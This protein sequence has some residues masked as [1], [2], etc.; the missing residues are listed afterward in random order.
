MRK[1]VILLI[2]ILVLISIFSIAYNLV[3]KYYVRFP[4]WSMDPRYEI[5]TIDE[6]FIT[7]LKPMQ[8][9]NT[10]FFPVKLHMAAIQVSDYEGKLVALINM[11]EQ[12]ILEPKSVND[13]KL[14]VALPLNLLNYPHLTERNKVD[15][16]FDGTVQGSVYSFPFTKKISG[17]FSLSP[18]AEWAEKIFKPLL[19]K[20]MSQNQLI[21]FKGARVIS[22]RVVRLEFIASTFSN[23]NIE[24]KSTDLQIRYGNDLVNTVLKHPVILNST[25]TSEVIE[26]DIKNSEWLHLRGNKKIQFRGR[27]TVNV[28]GVD[29][30][31][32]WTEQIEGIINYQI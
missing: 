15:L 3:R 29:T 11:T 6:N 8:M 16:F 5:L 10:M 4:S 23:I 28:F 14:K 17:T 7:L 26:F 19:M 21:R 20:I 12:T 27:S 24:L 31:V 1:Y 2:S 25:R 9:T 30:E 22:S 32:E 13:I 18:D